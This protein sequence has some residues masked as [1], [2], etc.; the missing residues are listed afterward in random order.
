M[1]IS[2]S[3]FVIIFIIFISLSPKLIKYTLKTSKHNPKCD[4]HML[5]NSNYKNITL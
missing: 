3:M 2:V 1:Y 4:V 5:Q